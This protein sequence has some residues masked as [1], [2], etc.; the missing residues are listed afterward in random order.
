MLTN[1]EVA[2]MNDAEIYESLIK[3]H[4]GSIKSAYGMRQKAIGAV[5]AGRAQEVFKHKFRDSSGSGTSQA[6][7]PSPLRPEFSAAMLLISNLKGIPFNRDDFKEAIE[8]EEL[9]SDNPVTGL[10]KTMLGSE[11]DAFKSAVGVRSDE[12]KLSSLLEEI[13]QAETMRKLLLTFGYKVIAPSWV[14]MA[15]KEG[16]TFL[17]V[18]R[19]RAQ[20]EVRSFPW[21]RMV[22]MDIDFSDFDCFAH[23]VPMGAEEE[24]EQPAVE[25]PAVEQPVEKQAVRRKR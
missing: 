6:A 21:N 20:G 7:G 25:Q 18:S 22:D 3:N 15:K 19:F 1:A 4:G 24:F 5:H 11:F 8:S 10:L 12:Q 2:K 23:F 13:A 14:D 16:A 9:A 17:A